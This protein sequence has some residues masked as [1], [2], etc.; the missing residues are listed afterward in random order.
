MVVVV[1]PAVK[2]CGAFFA[3]AVERAVGPAAEHGADEAFCFSVGLRSVGAGAEVADA[4]GAAGDRVDGGA[5]GRAVVGDHALDGDAVA[6]IEANGASQEGRG[7]GGAFVG[8][9][10]GV[11][12][13]GAVIDGDVDELP[14]VLELAAVIALGGARAEH[15]VTGTRD[16]AELFDVDVDQLSGPLALIALSWLEPQPPDPAHPD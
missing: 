11:G 13:A 2:G 12:Q 8:E 5:V 15:P 9:D 4:D 14:A 6:A 10:F 1:D 3:V 16:P 7:G